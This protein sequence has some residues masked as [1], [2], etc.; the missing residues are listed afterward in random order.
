MIFKKYALPFFKQGYSVLEIGAADNPST[1]QRIVGGKAVLWD[2][3][4]IAG[5]NEG[6]ASVHTAPTYIAKSEY[7][8]PIRNDRYD[9]VLSGQVIEHVRKVWR[10]MPELAR[11]CKPGGMV[12]TIGPVSWHY[13]EAP[14]DCSR[15]YPEGMKALSEDSG[16]EV[17]ISEWESV[18]LRSLSRLLRKTRH[19]R[20]CGLINLASG[21][22]KLPV[23]SSFDTITIARKPLL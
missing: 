2:S 8:F 17:V 9:V 7:S 20:L 14:V 22:L 3:L 15:I 21:M 4:D 18:E 19:Q 16:L 5:P 10:W 6:N 12:I 11:V 13:H 23:D 1:Y